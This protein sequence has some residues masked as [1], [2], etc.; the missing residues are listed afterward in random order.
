MR[1]KAMETLGETNKRKSESKDGSTS[2][3]DKSGRCA[4][5]LVDFLREKS[6]ADRE[7]RQQ[8]LEI[9]NQEQ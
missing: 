4:K 8:E 6:D 1:K 7:I 5:P 9:W 3:R 2:K